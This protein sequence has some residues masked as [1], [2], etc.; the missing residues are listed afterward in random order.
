MKILVVYYS[1]SG[2]TKLAAQTISKT[3]GADLEEIID[4]QSRSGAVGF[5][6]SCYQ[7]VLNQLT[8]IQEL[9]ADLAQYD[10]VVVGSP[11]WAG[12]PATPVTSFLKKYQSS[13]KSLAVFLT[14]GDKTNSYAGVVEFMEQAAGK[15]SVKTLSLSTDDVKK[16]NDYNM[17][18]FANELNKL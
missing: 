15:K 18:T 5:I 11:V 17:N 8:R 12:K 3:I 2:V 4:T 14:H 16:A 7:V 9:K 13:I 6:K 10:L 1:R